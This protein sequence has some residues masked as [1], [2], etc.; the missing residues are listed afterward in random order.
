MTD[1]RSP[2]D[3]DPIAPTSPTDG[4]PQRRHRAAV[5]NDPLAARMST[6]TVRGRRVRDLFQGFM[7]RVGTEADIVTQ[8]HCLQVAELMA[9]AEELRAKAKGE[10]LRPDMVNAITRAESTAARAERALFKDV[11]DAEAA[12]DKREH[13]RV[14]AEYRHT[15]TPPKDWYNNDQ[16]NNS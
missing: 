12:A 11:P 5:T 7:A 4:G 8:A 3:R 2:P 14:M 1:D 16:Q 6:R 9:I 13:D 15:P 10:E